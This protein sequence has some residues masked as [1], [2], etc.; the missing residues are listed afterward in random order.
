MR[1]HIIP[2]HVFVNHGL[3]DW[4]RLMMGE[5]MILV[6]RSFRASFLWLSLYGMLLDWD[7]VERISGIPAS[8]FATAKGIS[9]RPEY[10]FS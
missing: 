1:W 5:S 7:D 4:M 2:I 6:H 10:S 9:C 3:K 8:K